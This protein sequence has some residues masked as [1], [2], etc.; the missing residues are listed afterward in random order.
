VEIALQKL[1]PRHRFAAR[2]AAAPPQES[3]GAIRADARRERLI[4]MEL[5]LRPYRIACF[6][7]LAAVLASNSVALGWWWTLPLTFGLLGFA[8][9]DSFMRASDRPGIWIGGAW[10]MLPVLLASAV[11]STGGPTSPVLVWFALPA[12]TV[13][14]RF[15]PRA[16][17]AGTIYLLALLALCTF[18]Y[19][20][21]VAGEHQQELTAVAALVVCTVILSG[22]LVESDRA[23]RRRSTLDPLTGL[24]NRSALDQRLSEIEGQRSADGAGI[25][26]AVLLCDLDHFKRVNDQL[27][28]A[29]GDAVL[30]DV[31]YTMRGALRAGDSIYRVGGE[32]I[33]V[34]LP[35]TGRKEAEAVAERLR[36][37]VHDRRPVG[38]AV[39]ISIGAAVAPAGTLETGDLVARADAALYAAKSG[40]RDRVVVARTQRLRSMPPLRRAAKAAISSTVAS[41]SRRSTSSTG[42]CM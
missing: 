35:G 33:L 11:V 5:R 25:G 16:M 23:H 38:V 14:A 20:A 15:E 8:V 34:I 36:L 9:A 22:A 6:L 37:A 3:L 28:H 31:A 42:E 10:A 1:L 17:V 12:V 18:G 13:G 32:E 26:Y 4:D 39:T 19:D 29:A 21:G 24:F 27:G 40:G 2:P 41:T 7:I 30:Q